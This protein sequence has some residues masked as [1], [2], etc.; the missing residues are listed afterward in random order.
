MRNRTVFITG[1]TGIMGSWVMGQA[2]SRGYRPVVLM[3]DPSEAEAAERIRKALRLLN[4]EH[5]MEQVRIVR[6]DARMPGLGMVAPIR[7]QLRSELGGMIHCAAS[8]SFSPQSDRE[9]WETNVGGVSHILDFLAFSDVPLYHVST[10]YVAGKWHGDAY[11]DE[12]DPQR[13][14]NNTYE[15]SKCESE[16][17]VRR[18]VASG[19]VKATILRPGIIVGCTKAGLISQF[20]NFYGFLRYIDIV[21]SGRMKHSGPFRMVANPHGTKN[22]VPVDWVAKALWHIVEHE[23]PRGDAY[24]LTNPAPPTHEELR[25][26]ANK[27]IA[28]ND[29]H[30]AF[31]PRLEGKVSTLERFAH[32]SLKLYAPY[33]EGEPNFV[34]RNTARALNGAVPFPTMDAPFYSRLIQFARMQ[35]WQSIFTRRDAMDEIAEDSVIDGALAQS[36][37]V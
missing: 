26:W 15:R 12:L 28:N 18:A 30:L 23:E 29:T 32:S 5:R 37:A 22:L 16:S 2:L 19:A 10:A 34:W 27:F 4:M 35:E 6:G 36:V 20:M 9:V 25:A 1:A 17:M 7:D 13:E 24:Y 11:E 3:R 14:F 33:M 21:A 31:M 8:T